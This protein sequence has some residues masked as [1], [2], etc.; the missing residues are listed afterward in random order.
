M[1]LEMLDFKCLCFDFRFKLFLF[2]G[3]QQVFVLFTVDGM[4]IAKK[5]LHLADENQFDLVAMISA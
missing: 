4:N 3:F 5:F 2:F 1:H